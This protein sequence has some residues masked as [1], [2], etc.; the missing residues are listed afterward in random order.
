M[1][2]TQFEPLAGAFDDH[3]H[4]FF[5]NVEVMRARTAEGNVTLFLPVERVAKVLNLS[6]PQDED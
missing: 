1:I 5:R 3:K 6:L 2:L 4:P